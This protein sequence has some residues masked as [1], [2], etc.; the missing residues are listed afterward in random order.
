MLPTG[1][2]FF[3]CELVFATESVRVGGEA[4]M[5]RDDVPRK[6]VVLLFSG[7]LTEQFRGFDAR[8]LHVT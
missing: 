1:K 8:P 4:I 3:G 5:A 2:L 6:A 7:S